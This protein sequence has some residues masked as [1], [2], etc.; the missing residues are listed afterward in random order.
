[1]TFDTE[2]ILRSRLFLASLVLTYESQ[3][4]SPTMSGVVSALVHGR[5]LEFAQQIEADLALRTYLASSGA[6]QA[7]SAILEHAVTSLLG[8]FPAQD[9]PAG[10]IPRVELPPVQASSHAEAGAILAELDTSPSP[11]PAPVNRSRDRSPV[12]QSAER[13][14][15]PP[16]KTGGRLTESQRGALLDEQTCRICDRVFPTNRDLR[17]H[18]LGAHPEVK[19]HVCGECRI[20]Y[21][22]AEGLG[23]HAMTHVRQPHLA[24][25]K[26]PQ[27]FTHWNGLTAHMRSHG[28]ADA[29]LK[30]TLCDYGTRTPTSLRAHQTAH[31]T[32]HAFEEVLSRCLSH[33]S[34]V[35]E[36]TNKL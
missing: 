16:L 25:G 24:C 32:A 14:R 28:N 9:S 30:C 8:E 4:P 12:R 33:D 23:R 27:A 7:V 3:L 26:C 1:M 34:P 20:G 31:R 21:Q 5:L 10:P 19:L 11:Q 13:G 18:S 36:Q 35:Q 17:R 2:F 22:T 6:R 29:T 15:L